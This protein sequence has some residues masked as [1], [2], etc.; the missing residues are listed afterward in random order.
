MCNQGG[1][2][3]ISWHFEL[4]L[5]NGDRLHPLRPQRTHS[6]EFSTVRDGCERGWIEYSLPRGASPEAL[7]YRYDDTGSNQPG[8]HRSEHDHF[9]W[10][11]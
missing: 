4:R 8:D 3:V 10:S 5:A 1:Q 2:A 11:L 7:E 9:V 6:P